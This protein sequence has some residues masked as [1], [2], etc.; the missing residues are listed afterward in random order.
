MHKSAITDH[1]TQQNHIFD[2]ERAQG[3]PIC[4]QRVGLENK[5][6]QKSDMDKAIP[7]LTHLRCS[8]EEPPRVR[9]RGAHTRVIHLRRINTL[10]PSSGS[11]LKR[12]ADS[13]RN[14][15]RKIR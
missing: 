15:T 12:I 6:H 5:R 1:M 14:V 7:T 11:R 3:G 10:S 2:W 9:P 4:R 8:P 13:N